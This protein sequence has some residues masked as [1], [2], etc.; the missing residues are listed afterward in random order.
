M[1]SLEIM[2]EPLLHTALINRLGSA[3]IPVQRLAPPWRRTLGWLLLVVAIALGLL[4]HYGP[5]GMLQRWLAA[6]DLGWAGLGAAVT[7]VCAAWAAFALAVPGRRVTW[8]W[9]PLP[10]PWRAGRVTGPETDREGP[11]HLRVS[12]PAAGG[13]VRA[14]PAHPPDRGRVG[15]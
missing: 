12:G 9:L 1:E 8:A 5:G 13:E 2:S 3:L 4:L 6:P 11:V 10:G 7:A 14:R 15:P